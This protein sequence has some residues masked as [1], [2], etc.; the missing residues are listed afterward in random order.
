MRQI[1]RTTFIAIVA[2]AAFSSCKKDDKSRVELLTSAN[3]KLVSD[4][5]K[6]GTGPWEEYIDDYEACE[7]DNYIKFNNNNSAEFNEGLTKCDPTD[8]QV[9]SLPW[10]FQ[11]DES[12]INMDGEILDIEELS[13]S[14]LIVT[15]SETYAGT[16]YYYKQIL[17]H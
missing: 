5:E 9:Y 12:Q 17:K 15:T 4:Q 10:A 3:W 11:N 8:D 1:I 7:L 6:A 14:T 16:T 13:G 2:V